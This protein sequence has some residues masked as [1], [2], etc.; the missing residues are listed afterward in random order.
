[1]NIE[2]FKIIKF[3]NDLLRKKWRY[4]FKTCQFGS[5]N[6]VV[7]L[8]LVICS[9]RAEKEKKMKEKRTVLLNTLNKE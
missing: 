8:F 3:K 2:S 6:E 4:P 5:I 9:L 7:R 1:M